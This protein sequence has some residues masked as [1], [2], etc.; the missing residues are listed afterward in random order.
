MEDEVEGAVR[1]DS[2]RTSAGYNPCN[3]L[4]YLTG[5]LSI[6]F[7]EGTWHVA[8]PAIRVIELEGK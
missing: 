6:R 5:Q 8:N 1:D 7:H 2:D 4:L 3:V